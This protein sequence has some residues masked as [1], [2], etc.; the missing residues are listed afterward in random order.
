[1]TKQGALQELGPQPIL[2]QPVLLC[3]EAYPSGLRRGRSVL[4]DTGREVASSLGFQAIDKPL[5]NRR[6]LSFTRP[7]S[8]HQLGERHV[9][10]HCWSSRKRTPTVFRHCSNRRVKNCRCCVPCL[11]RGRGGSHP[12]DT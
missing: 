3:E 7:H 12:D 10:V 2:V 5:N 9:L 1:M 4:A 11:M 8:S 6:R